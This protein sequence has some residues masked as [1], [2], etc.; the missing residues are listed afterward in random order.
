MGKLKN[1]IINLGSKVNG[2]EPTGHYVTELLRSFGSTLT[3]E[4]LTGKT[5]PEIIDD[6]AD[7]YSP[8][9]PEL[10]LNVEVVTGSV[11]LLGKVA[12]DLQENVVIGTYGITGTLKYVTDYTGFSSKVE[13]QSGNYI[14]LKATSVS[15]ATIK[16]EITGGTSGPV[17]LDDDGIIIFRVKNI[18]Q[19]VMFTATVDDNK[20]IMVGYD[21][22]EMTLEPAPEQEPTENNQE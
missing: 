16:A 8:A 10:S 18:S 15:G 3:G 6:I 20:T 12:S 19:Q 11:D 22:R 2:V 14:A 7:N 17:T 9:T 4:T 1:S 5:I 13:E 21:L